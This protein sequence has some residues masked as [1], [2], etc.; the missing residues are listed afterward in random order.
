MSKNEY[1][2]LKKILNVLYVQLW[3]IL[4]LKIN[5]KHKLFAK[6]FKIRILKMIQAS[7]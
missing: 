3:R 4:S 7:Y 1:K 6:G 2:F 5:N